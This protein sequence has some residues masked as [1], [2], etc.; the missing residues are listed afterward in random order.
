V[1]VGLLAS[2]GIG[3]AAWCW[4]TP[5]VQMVSQLPF[6]ESPQVLAARARDIAASLGYTAPSVDTASGFREQ[7]GYVS[8]VD[9]E[10]SGS[11]AEKRQ[12]WSR[13]LADAPSP[14]AFWYREA[15]API[16]PVRPIGIITHLD[17]PVATPG[18]LAM[19]L[20]LDG[21]L[22]RFSASSAQPQAQLPPNWSRYFE[23]ARLDMAQFQPTA[24]ATDHAGGVAWT[25]IYPGAGEFPV[26][27]EATASAQ[28]T[29]FAI[30]FPWN[31]A[32]ASELSP[33]L[34]AISLTTLP[35]LG[36]L[37]AV[38]V[39]AR[40]NWIAGRVDRSGAWQIAVLICVTLFLG[41]HLITWDMANLFR[42]L[43][44]FGLY[45]C[46]AFGV[47][48]ATFYLALEPWGRRYW[49]ETLVTW[50]RVVAGRWNDPLVGRDVLIALLGAVLLSCVHRVLYLWI[51]STGGAPAGIAF[52]P[53]PDG[54]G[55][56]GFG[57][58]LVNLMGARQSSG[59]ML[60]ALIVGLSNSLSAVFC[61]FPLPGSVTEASSV[62]S[63][64][65]RLREHR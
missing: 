60:L 25:G 5:M 23:A 32:G 63:R 29:S 10:M 38:V 59:A 58:T 11:A 26:R 41:I 40:R 4:L 51:T 19:D 28:T 33:I 50:S 7:T 56:G 53:N 57:F 6:A 17:S 48:T 44:E 22:L 8:Y 64:R 42:Y 55:A 14:I 16:V 35:W 52:N 61:R 1:A 47:Q 21:R 45:V 39:I 30:L 12:R 34:P 36:I 43:L 54:I 49:P 3:L 18:M 27:I 31:E 20:G 46:V 24:P 37:V 15:E 13:L 62:G 2:I 65:N 9:R